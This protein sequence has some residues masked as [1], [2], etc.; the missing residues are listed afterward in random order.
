M[1]GERARA[2]GGDVCDVLDVV[3]GV[4]IR[5]QEA[6]QAVWHEVRA[7]VADVGVEVDGGPAG[8]EANA[9]RLKRS[10]LLF[11]AGQRVVNAHGRAFGARTA[12]LK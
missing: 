7:Q 1:L 9:P 6:E 8:V 3:S 10:K 2:Q 4:C 11:L 12:P 5:Y